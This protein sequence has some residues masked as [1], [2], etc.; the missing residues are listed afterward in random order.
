MEPFTLLDFIR[1]SNRIEG[2]VRK[3]LPTERCAANTF[4][5]SA[6]IGI[7]HMEMLVSAFQPDACLRSQAGMDVR[8]GRYTAPP[9]GK[10]IVADLEMLLHFVNSRQM[11]AY[12][13]HLRYEMIHPFTDGNG[14]SGRMLWL[15]QI[16][17]IENAPL[18]F[19]HHFY[20]Q[21]L[22]NIK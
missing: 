10:N 6:A 2:I 17:G 1:E 15:W 21:T 11:D 22:A 7:E 9:G 3:V 16:G 19:L 8:V 20:Y 5:A 4:L 14:R 13:A 12:K 18:G